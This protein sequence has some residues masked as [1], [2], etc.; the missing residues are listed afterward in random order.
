MLMVAPEGPGPGPGPGPESSP[1][2]C[3]RS[4]PSSVTWSRILLVQDGD[5][6]ASPLTLELRGGV[7]NG[8]SFR[9]D[10]FNV[11]SAEGAAAPSRRSPAPLRPGDAGWS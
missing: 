4:S 11:F 7:R 5:L 8:S 9:L 10:V 2:C 1:P 3:C 6:S